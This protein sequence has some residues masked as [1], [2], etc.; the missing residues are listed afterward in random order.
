MAGRNRV[1]SVLPGA[2]SESVTTVPIV[3]ETLTPHPVVM[4]H[5]TAE[6]R[7]IRWMHPVDG[8]MLIGYGD[9]TNNLGPIS[10]IGYNMTTLAPVT[11]F[12]PVPSES[13]ERIRIIDGHV[14]LPHTDPLGAT[15]MGA[16]TTNRSGSWENVTIGHM[17][18]VYDVIKF[19]GSIYV[20]GSANTPVVDVG[21]GI[22]YKETSPGIWKVVLRGTHKSAL[23]RFYQ[24]H[25]DGDFL[26]VQTRAEEALS[27]P[28]FRTANGE[29]WEVVPGHPVLSAN[30][31]D[32]PTITPPSYPGFGPT[33]AAVHGGWV[34]VG[35]A[36]GAV[37]RTRLP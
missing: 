25:P 29:D 13:F 27:E 35:G 24:F 30:D 6:H 9:Y 31:N 17:V 14:Y 3:W 5:T 7:Q 15:H 8:V 22:V 28:T 20:C 23:S 34:W 1:T 4:A 11:V 33:A 2:I 32:P 12:G 10:V 36:N 26:K 37:K 18:H 21:Q 16:I 19:K